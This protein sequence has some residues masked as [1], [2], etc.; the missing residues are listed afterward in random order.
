[1]CHMS[2]VEKK[3]KKKEEKNFALKKLGQSGGAGQWR[4]CYQRGL[5]RLFFFIIVT[6]FETKRGS[7]VGWTLHVLTLPLG[8][9][10]PFQKPFV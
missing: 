1:M 10:N 5:H 6:E 3:R 9:L 7:Q 4:V 8:K 2:H